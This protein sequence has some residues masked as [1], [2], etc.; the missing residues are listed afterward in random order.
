MLRSRIKTLRIFLKLALERKIY[1]WDNITNKEYINYINILFI[2]YIGMF[3]QQYACF[4]T[5]ISLTCKV[6]MADLTTMVIRAYY[7]YL[8]QNWK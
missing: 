5:E 4:K 6:S 3:M 8:R 7:S 1:I 2:I